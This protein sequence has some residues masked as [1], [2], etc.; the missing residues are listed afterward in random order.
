ML[1]L[2]DRWIPTSLLAKD[3]EDLCHVDPNAWEANRFLEDLFDVDRPV[4]DQASLKSAEL[5][6]SI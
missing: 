5:T 1:K 2:Q 6:K 4:P 3:V